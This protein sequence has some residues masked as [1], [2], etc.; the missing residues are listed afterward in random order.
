[1]TLK[2]GKT[3]AA[4]NATLHNNTGIGQVMSTASFS[5]TQT[6]K[7][8]TKASHSTGTSMTTTAEMK[9]PFVSGSMSLNVKYDFSYNKSVESTE[10]K[11]WVVPSQNITVPAGHKYRVDWILNIGVARGTTDLTSYVKATIPFKMNS[12][13]GTRYGLTLR[14]SIRN[15]DRFFSSITNSPYIWGARQNWE[16]YNDNAAIRKWGVAQY[17]AEFGTELVMTITDVRAPFMVQKTTR[18]GISSKTT[19]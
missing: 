11:Q 16:R 9:F 7:V 15:Y 1:M 4:H 19:N 8:T 5:Y 6:D 2:D 13:N 14:D 12:N 10:T 3:L 18:G 17:E